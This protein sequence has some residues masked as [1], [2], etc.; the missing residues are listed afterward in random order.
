MHEKGKVLVV[1]DN[2]FGIRWLLD[3]LKFHQYEAELVTNEES[4]M[5]KLELVQE[6]KLKYHLAIFDVMVATQRIE[7]VEKL[8]DE[9]FRDS[10]D[11][12]VRLCRYA[13]LELG[14]SPSELDIVC[15]SGRGDEDLVDATRRLGIPLFNRS[16][17][18]AF[19]KFLK[20]KL[21]FESKQT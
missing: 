18:T 17:T 2:E 16:Q 7:D 14:L 21:S 20:E 15:I 1:D 3:L 9:F 10:M 19:R 5:R 8:D 13:R 6:K 11:T 4:A 12:G